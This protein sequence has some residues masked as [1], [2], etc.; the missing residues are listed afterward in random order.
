MT[1]LQVAMM[2]SDHGFHIR[3]SMSRMLLSMF[4]LVDVSH[5]IDQGWGHG[6]V[7]FLVN[8]VLLVKNW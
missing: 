3:N 5:G 2:L 4:P 8:Q 1:T 7:Q 6:S